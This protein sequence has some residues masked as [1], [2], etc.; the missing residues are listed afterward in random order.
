MSTIFHYT[1]G[2]NLF[3]ILMS[4]EIKTEAVTGVRLHPSVTNFAWFTAEERF[5]KL[6][7]LTFQKCQKQIFNYIWAQKNLMLTC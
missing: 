2:Y 1:K 6:H 3:D 5:P 7:Y 4:Q